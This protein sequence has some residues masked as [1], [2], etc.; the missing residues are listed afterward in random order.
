MGLQ[1]SR[2]CQ[3]RK[4]QLP[5]LPNHARRFIPVQ[6]SSLSQPQ[7]SELPEIAEPA[8]DKKQ[9]GLQIIIA[10]SRRSRGHIEAWCRLA[11]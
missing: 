3:G 5:L 9:H 7:V 1:G 4:R 11:S 6:A 2:A 10:A 8:E